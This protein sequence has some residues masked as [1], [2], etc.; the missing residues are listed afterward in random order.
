MHLYNTSTHH[1]INV[2]SY[3]EINIKGE[4][5]ILKQKQLFNTMHCAMTM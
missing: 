5:Q 1:K 2:E 3:W 4:H